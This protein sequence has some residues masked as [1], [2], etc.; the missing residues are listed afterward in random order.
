M[1]FDALDAL[2]FCS[3][4]MKILFQNKKWNEYLIEKMYDM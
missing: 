2:V 4:A 1:A 3:F